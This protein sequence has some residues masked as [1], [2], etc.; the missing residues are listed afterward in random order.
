MRLTDLPRTTG[1]RLSALFLALFGLS[2][3]ILFAFLYAQTNH[4]LLSSVDARLQREAL[5]DLAAPAGIPERLRAH[6]QRDPEGLRPFGL[7]DATGHPVT[8]QLDWLPLR[9]PP[10]KRP[11]EFTLMH[12]GHEMPFRGVAYS[13]PGD[14]TLVLSESVYEIYELRGQLVRAIA[15]G[16]ILVLAVGLTGAV[17]TGRDTERRISGITSAIERIV[18]GDLA[19]RLPTRTR[20]GDVDRLAHLVNAMLDDIE[21]LMREV[22]GVTDDIAHD[23]RTPLTRLLA[24]LERAR[25]RAVSMQEYEQAVSAAITETQALLGTFSGLLRIAEVE[26]GARRAGFTRIDLGKIVTDV[27]EFHLP[28]AEESGVSLTHEMHRGAAAV[29]MSGDSSL[30]FEAISNLVDNAIKFALPG[31]HVTARTFRSAGKL[32]VVVVDDGP[33]IP[34]EERE[35]VLRRF[36]RL[37]KSRHASGSGLGL[38]LVAAVAKLHGLSL[39]IGSANPGCCVTLSREESVEE[40]AQRPALQTACGGAPALS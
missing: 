27:V 15:W 20:W 38:S 12:A 37:E 30:L 16:S 18:D 19:E 26:A 33:G 40:G 32:G 22:K 21:R 25:R 17:L 8:G 39:T 34:E 4:Y 1:F 7:F 36:H 14:E 9:P 29:E 31:G 28:V 10:L 24:G 2:S 3:L 11:F 13:L 5:A 35:A 6:A 23:L